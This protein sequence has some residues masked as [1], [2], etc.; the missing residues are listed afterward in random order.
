MLARALEESGLSTVQVTMLRE[1]SLRVKPPRA[2]FVP[3]PFGRPL[4]AADDPALQLRVI[5]AALA[6]LTTGSFRWSLGPGTFFS[7]RA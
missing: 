4:G 1:H 2:L 3:F 7:L 6:L 5:R